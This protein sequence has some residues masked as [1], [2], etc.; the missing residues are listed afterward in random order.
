MLQCQDSRGGEH[1]SLCRFS[2]LVP[3][4]YPHTGAPLVSY[5][6]KPTSQILYNVHHQ[7]K[8]RTKPKA[9]QEEPYV[10]PQMQR[11]MRYLHRPDEH[12]GNVIH[13][14]VVGVMH[15]ASPGDFSQHLG[16][17]ISIAPPRTCLQDDFCSLLVGND[18]P[19]AICR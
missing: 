17:G 19:H 3:E 8:A 11:L 16:S 4:N 13:V 7:C 15:P 1:G 9:V 12:N 10:W 5:N 18:V 14:G 2:C 6:T